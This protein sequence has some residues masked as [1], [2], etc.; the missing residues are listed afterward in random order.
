MVK[1]LLDP[2]YLH[3]FFPGYGETSGFSTIPNE[4]KPAYKFSIERILFLIA[5]LT[6][7]AEFRKP[8]FSRI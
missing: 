4:A 1:W 7:S 3:S 6:S 5:Y 2:M 8:S